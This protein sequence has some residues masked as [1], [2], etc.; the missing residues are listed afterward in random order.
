MSCFIVGTSV[1]AEVVYRFDGSN[2]DEKIPLQ[3]FSVQLS[4]SS[5]DVAIALN[6]LGAVSH[7]LGLVAAKEDDRLALLQL[8]IKKHKIN[9]TLLPCLN[10]TSIAVLP[11]DDTSGKNRVIGQRGGVIPERISDIAQMIVNEAASFGWRI[12]TGIR[13]EEIP[14]AQALLGTNKG[15][16]VLNP[17][18]TLCRDQELEALLP[19]VD[20]LVLNKNEMAVSRTTFKKCH[21]LG[22]SLVIVTEDE[23]GGQYS[24]RGEV[25]RFTPAKVSSSALYLAGAGD[26]FLGGFLSFCDLAHLDAA[27]D[28]VDIERALA[29][30]ARVA[31]K[32]ITMKGAGNGPMLSEI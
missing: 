19:F 21:E 7:L 11:C 14:F 27:S 16:R 29:F 30:G 6:Q 24:L 10:K 25:G 20:I 22:T 32:K 3:D 15:K 13:A 23:N 5:G 28:A 18:F 1:N 4:G 12:A 2:P 9:S 8:A 31:A 17:N 26:W